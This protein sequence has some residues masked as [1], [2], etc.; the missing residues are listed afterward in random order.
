LEFA[1]KVT[2]QD[3]CFERN[4][5]SF[6]FIIRNEED[7]LKF[8]TKRKNKVNFVD[9]QKEIKEDFLNGRME[10]KI[11][12]NMENKKIGTVYAYSLNTFEKYCFFSIFLFKKY[13]NNVYGVA[14]VFGYLSIMFE[15]YFIDKI[16]F[17]VYEY[18]ENVLKMIRK[19]KKIFI[20]VKYFP[21]KKEL[22]GIQ[23]GIFRFVIFRSALWS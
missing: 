3:F 12:I 19:L 13:Q 6:L 22:N 20:F 1:K 9:F 15:K 18:N 14:S 21:E 5:Q 10:Q 4:F 8:C 17:D 16:F 7:F 23:Y 2:F 11:I